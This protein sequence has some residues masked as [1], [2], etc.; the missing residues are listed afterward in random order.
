MLTTELQNVYFETD[1]LTMKMQASSDSK[2]FVTIAML[3]AKDIGTAKQPEVGM[4]VPHSPPSI[5]AVAPPS[6]SM[7]A[8]ASPLYCL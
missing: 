6:T 3:Y 4:I 1:K 7:D 5:V 2:G 8:V